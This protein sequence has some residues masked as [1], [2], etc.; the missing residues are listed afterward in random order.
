M[1]TFYSLAKKGTQQKCPRMLLIKINLGLH[2]YA[3]SPVADSVDIGFISVLYIEEGAKHETR[4]NLS[5]TIVG[6]DTVL[7][8][9]IVPCTLAIHLYMCG[10]CMHKINIVYM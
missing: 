3:R 6:E 9:H 2:V 7:D 1:A 4:P 8:S 5:S 10:V